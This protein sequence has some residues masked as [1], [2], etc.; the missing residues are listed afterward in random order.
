MTLSK[1]RGENG[2]ELAVD[3]LIKH[4]YRILERNYRHK[5]AEIDIIAY[6]DKILCFIEVKY[7]SGS[8]FGNPEDFVSEKQKERIREGAEEYMMEALE[9]DDIRFDLIAISSKS[10]KI[11]IEHFK[12][13]F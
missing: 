6:K 3:F 9:H 7:R 13:A 4:D 8:E 1:K 11:E 10:E 5:R 2:E 12:D